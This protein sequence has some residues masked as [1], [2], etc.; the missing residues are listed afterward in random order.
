MWSFWNIG[1]ILGA[2]FTGLNFHGR[3]SNNYYVLFNFC[4]KPTSKQEAE[5]TLPGDF[6]KSG[7][8]AFLFFSFFFFN[9]FIGL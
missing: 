9:I 4:G 3:V 2:H 5:I 1:E 8:V 6:L 7:G